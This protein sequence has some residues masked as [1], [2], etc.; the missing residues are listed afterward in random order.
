MSEEKEKLQLK[1]QGVSQE[2]L[3]DS[4]SVSS[5]RTRSRVVRTPIEF[6]EIDMCMY[7]LENHRLE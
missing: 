2:D 3:S 5:R 1:M 6:D 7:R 4:I